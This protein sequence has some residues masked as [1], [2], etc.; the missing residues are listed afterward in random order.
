MKNDYLCFLSSLNF[1]RKRVC[2]NPI[3]ASEYNAQLEMSAKVK[4]EKMKEKRKVENKVPPP[5]ITA[6]TDLSDHLAKS[7]E[8][9][10]A[11]QS[12]SS[13]SL[14]ENSKPENRKETSSVVP[15]LKEK[16]KRVPNYRNLLTGGFNTKP[17]SFKSRRPATQSSQN[18]SARS[19][20]YQLTNLQ[21]KTTNEL[22]QS[23]AAQPDPVPEPPKP[24]G[25]PKR[26]PPPPP[27]KLKSSLLENG[28]A[29]Q[30]SRMA[31]LLHC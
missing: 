25:R 27:S 7:S 29:N 20:G 9:R 5:Y 19:S 3:R 1:V 28:A 23:L 31:F 4:V 18:A 16:R 10:P 26:I 12:S 6:P 13:D 8:N 22:L 17:Y 2:L 30:V 21:A 24:R 11:K 15:G 14:G